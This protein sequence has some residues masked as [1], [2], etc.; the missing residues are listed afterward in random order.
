MHIP[1][2][3][4]AA[5]TPA[6]GIPVRPAPRFL[7]RPPQGA[8]AEPA[9]RIRPGPQRASRPVR[10]AC[11]GSKSHIVGLL[12]LRSVLGGLFATSAR[13]RPFQSPVDSDRPLEVCVTG[14]YRGGRFR[15][16]R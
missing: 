3:D 4:L 15:D 11:S 5:G 10:A 1:R 2:F 12:F 6:G 8:S 9:R 14:L 13:S 16:S 7:T